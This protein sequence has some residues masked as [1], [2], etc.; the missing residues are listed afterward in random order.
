MT[1]RLDRV[2]VLL[3]Q[4]ISQVLAT[5]LKDPRLYSMVSVTRVEA[6]RDLNL[7]KVHVSVYGDLTDKRKAMKALRSAAGFI[8]RNMRSKLALRS[9]PT[10][11][12]V[13]DDSIEMGAEMLQTINEVVSELDDRPQP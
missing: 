1:R 13:L 7:A 4:E 10:L 11:N 6:T 2:N 5:E 12:F 3:R 9:V 8:R